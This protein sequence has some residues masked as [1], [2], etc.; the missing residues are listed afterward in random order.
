MFVRAEIGQGG[1]SRIKLVCSGVLSEVGER[2][3]R[4]KALGEESW[5]W[6]VQARIST[7][8]DPA[9]EAGDERCTIEKME[10]EV[11]GEIEDKKE[12]EEDVVAHEEEE[13]EEGDEKEENEE[14][15][16]GDG[17]SEFD[18]PQLGDVVV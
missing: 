18:A 7:S 2:F 9:E 8:G 15:E 1:C 11:E 4:A 13:K 3:G 6:L 10:E 5:A 16:K 12:V 14:E 17:M